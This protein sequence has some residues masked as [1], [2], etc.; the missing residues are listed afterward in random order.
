MIPDYVIPLDSIPLTNSHKVDK[1]KLPAPGSAD[2]FMIANGS[3]IKWSAE[4]DGRRE[5]VEAILKVFASVLFTDK[6]LSPND[7][8]F[9]C[10]GHS[11]L[12]TKATSLIRRELDVALPF[13]AIITYPTASQLAKQVEAIKL[14][15]SPQLPSNIVSLQATP[16][17]EP[18]AVL[19]V[20]H[21]VA[22][23]LDKMPQVLEQLNLED[24]G[25]AAYG[26]VWEPGQG[27]NTLEKIAAAYAESVATV[28]GSTPCFLLGWCYGG[29]I[30]TQVSQRLPMATTSVLLL[31]SPSLERI[32][33][34][35]PE[36]SDYA[37]TFINQ[38]CAMLYQQSFD[39]DDVLSVRMRM[40]Q[41][42]DREKIMRLFIEAKIDRHDIPRLTS[43]AREHMTLPSWVTDSDFSRYL[44]PLAD[45]YDILQDVYEHYFFS[46][47][48]LEA[49]EEQVILNLQCPIPATGLPL[50]LG[51]SRY[52]LV[53]A[54]RAYFPYH[55]DVVSR[56]SNFLREY[57]F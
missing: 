12:A 57:P 24:L 27:L 22:G 7:N 45:S 52:E 39:L 34:L 15:L 33:R 14:Q 53:N 42:L 49:M 20:F 51:W 3:S 16:I 30:A 18:R 21:F 55:P 19:F 23:E 9:L 25:I 46:R 56:L 37:T 48:D 29:M 1:A 38:I 13:T 36:E 11:L 44:V 17:V 5:I 43:F 47:F 35:E 2:R 10:G 26:V 31:N 8:F 4:D 50:G 32:C 41:E 40:R 28:A 6:T 54:G